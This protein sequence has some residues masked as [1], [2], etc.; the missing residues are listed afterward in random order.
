MVRGTELN[1]RS[2]PEPTL[3]QV[4]E[5]AKWGELRFEPMERR[6]KGVFC[7]AESG[8]GVNFTLRTQAGALLW[9]GP[10]KRRNS[11]AI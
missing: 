5:R 2:Q 1:K 8:F 7:E 9:K 4:G 10:K 3:A 6:R 11:N